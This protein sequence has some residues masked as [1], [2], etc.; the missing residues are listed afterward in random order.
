MHKITRAENIFLKEMLSKGEIAA[1]TE[2]VDLSVAL[3]GGEK[4]IAVEF[5]S[6]TRELKA[7]RYGL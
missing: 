3:K 6:S 7:F 5:L 2:G 4:V 1:P